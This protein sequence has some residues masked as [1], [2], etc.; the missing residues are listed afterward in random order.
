MELIIFLV[1]LVLNLL[2]NFNYKRDIII[3]KCIDN[4]TCD[5]QLYLKDFMIRKGNKI[6]FMKTNS[7]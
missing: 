3:I 6:E 1:V 7:T 2:L 4:E 5:K